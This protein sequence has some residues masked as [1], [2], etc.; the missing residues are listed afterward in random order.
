ML[1]KENVP[2]MFVTS[3]LTLH[4]WTLQAGCTVPNVIS[5]HLYEMRFV[6][7]YDPFS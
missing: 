6:L 5:N 1:S 3:D 2:Y 4:P 7:S